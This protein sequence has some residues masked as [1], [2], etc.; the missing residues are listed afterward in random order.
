MESIIAS[1]EDTLLP[2]LDHRLEKTA[3]CIESR[4]EVTSF[5]SVPIASST[6]VKVLPF[7]ITSAQ[8][9]D[10]HSVYFSFTVRNNDAPQQLIP[11]C[12]GAHGFIHRFIL[13][14]NGQTV[15]DINYYDRLHEQFERVLPF[16]KRLDNA[17]IGFGALSFAY[18]GTWTTI[19]LAGERRG[20]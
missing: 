3:R 5:S 2:Q 10:P 14:I 17:N 20:A 15:E 16:G 7:Q 4:E 11:L 1:S 13:S 12:Q 6:S 8:F 19:P 18:G 9:I